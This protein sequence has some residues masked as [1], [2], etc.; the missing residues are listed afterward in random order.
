MAR[1]AEKRMQM[2]VRHGGIGG[3]VR[4]KL[5]DVLSITKGE[6]TNLDKDLAVKKKRGHQTTVIVHQQSRH[7]IPG[8]AV[9]RIGERL[10]IVAKGQA[11]EELHQDVHK[12]YRY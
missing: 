6:K 12:L 10:G 8:E 1:H 4:M 9:R 5:E 3:V 11:I 2:R 7:A